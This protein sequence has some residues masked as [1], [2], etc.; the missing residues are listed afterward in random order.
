MLLA[1]IQQCIEAGR[2]HFTDHALTKHPLDEGFT[3]ADA[4][5]AI[6]RGTIIEHRAEEC[7]CLICGDVPKLAP[8]PRF[9]TNHLHCSVE[10]DPDDE[11]VIVTVYRPDS[12][13]WVNQFTRRKS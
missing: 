8:S 7:R 12:G 3:A 1:W 9:I 2:Y 6:Q 5:L 10:W 11:V 4:I 13:Q